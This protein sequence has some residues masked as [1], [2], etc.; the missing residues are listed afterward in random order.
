MF[1]S[2][3]PLAEH[4]VHERANAELVHGP[5]RHHGVPVAQHSYLVRETANFLEDVRN[6]QD[7]N[8]LRS[9]GSE[10]RDEALAVPGV[11]RRRGLVKD[12]HLWLTENGARYLDNLLLPHAQFAHPCR[13]RDVQTKR[14]QGW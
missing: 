4:R 12:E 1:G 11:E 10:Q 3:G 2:G 5:C 13:D 9:Q 6:D 14:R 8:V 7:G